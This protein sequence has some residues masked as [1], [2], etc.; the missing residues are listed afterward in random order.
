MCTTIMETWLKIFE[1]K[2]EIAG[3]PCSDLALIV[4][5][6]TACKTCQFNISRE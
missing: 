6:V 3:T 2:K 5:E 1:E 4:Y